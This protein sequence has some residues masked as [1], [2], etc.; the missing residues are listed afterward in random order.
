MKLIQGEVEDYSRLGSKWV[1]S[2]KRSR[3][4]D[5]TLDSLAAKKDWMELEEIMRLKESLL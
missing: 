1:T 4:V 3:R 5:S 2:M